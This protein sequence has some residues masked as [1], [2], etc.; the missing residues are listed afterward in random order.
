MLLIISVVFQPTKSK[1]LEFVTLFHK[2][3][4]RLRLSYTRRA[5][6]LM[7]QVHLFTGNQCSRTLSRDVGL[8]NYKLCAALTCLYVTH[9]TCLF[10]AF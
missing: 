10:L 5:F 3:W 8:F 6:H 2:V 1:I 4:H 7:K 9:T